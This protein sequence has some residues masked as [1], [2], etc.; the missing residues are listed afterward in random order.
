M[1]TKSYTLTDGTTATVNATDNGVPF[2]EGMNVL[3]KAIKAR[4]NTNDYSTATSLQ[5][6]LMSAADKQKLDCFTLME[7]ETTIGGSVSYV[8]PNYVEVTGNNNGTYFVEVRNKNTGKLYY[9]GVDTPDGFWQMDLGSEEDK[10]EIL[11][12]LINRGRITDEQVIEDYEIRVVQ[13]VYCPSVRIGNMLISHEIVAESEHV[14]EGWHQLAIAIDVDKDG[15]SDDVFVIPGD[16]GASLAAMDSRVESLE[17]QDGVPEHYYGD[18][19]ITAADSINGGKLNMGGGSYG[20]IIDLSGTVRGGRINL[21]GTN[22]RNGSQ[23]GT[24]DASGRGD[25]GIIYLI[26][27]CWKG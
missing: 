19:T 22:D 14:G 26:G 3:T 16:L 1:S 20:G 27:N 8:V 11:R 10:A 4:M 24:I 21:S 13:A 25:G 2:N 6:G 9:S 5:S 18:V 17:A 15:T 12:Y 7:T 23:G